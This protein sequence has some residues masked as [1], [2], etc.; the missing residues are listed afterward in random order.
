MQNLP[1]IFV[2]LPQTAAANKATEV[3]GREFAQFAFL[4]WKNNGHDH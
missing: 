1:A 4:V 3:C 2:H